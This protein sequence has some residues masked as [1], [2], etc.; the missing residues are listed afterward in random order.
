MGER[1]ERKT[2]YQA[3][4]CKT[5]IQVRSG[6]EGRGEGEDWGEVEWTQENTAGEYERHTWRDWGEARWGPPRVRLVAWMPRWG[7]W[8]WLETIGGP[9]SRSILTV[10]QVWMHNHLENL[11]NSRLVRPIS[12]DSDQ[13]GWVGIMNLHFSK[14]PR[15]FKDCSLVIIRETQDS[16]SLSHWV[17]DPGFLSDFVDSDEE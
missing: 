14:L 7:V 9:C 5:Q 8:V 1:E 4:V 3:Q 13:E 6:G 10:S 16:P 12:R 2:P 11:L 15:W 17:Q